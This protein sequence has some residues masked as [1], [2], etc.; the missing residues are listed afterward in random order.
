MFSILVHICFLIMLY[1]RLYISPSLLPNPMPS[2]AHPFGRPR[3]P[4]RRQWPIAVGAG[5]PL[6]GIADGPRPHGGHATLTGHAG[7]M[8]SIGTAWEV[9]LVGLSSSLAFL[10]GGICA[11][12]KLASSVP[13]RPRRLIFLFVAPIMYIIICTY[14]HVTNTQHNAN[15]YVRGA[16]YRAYI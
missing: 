15:T 12:C 9:A 13:P 8:P 16:N 11:F 3:A 6:P 7:V 14:I 4:R 10:G 5:H 1:V 2:P